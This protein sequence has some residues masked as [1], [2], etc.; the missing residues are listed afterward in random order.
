MLVQ[1]AA[2]GLKP[3]GQKL[4]IDCFISLLSE[5]TAKPSQGRFYLVFNVV[6]LEFKYPLPP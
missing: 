1:E 6:W 3:I 4:R 2:I 5:R